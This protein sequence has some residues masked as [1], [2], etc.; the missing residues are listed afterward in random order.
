MSCR[1]SADKTGQVHRQPGQPAYPWTDLTWLLYHH[2]VSWAYYISAGAQPDCNHGIMGCHFRPQNA[3]TPSIWNP[4]PRF[5]D[6][7]QTHQVNHV[8]DTS[9]FF[10]AAR[11]GRLPAVSWVIPNYAQSEHPPASIARGQA[12]VTSVVNAVMRSKDWRSSAIFLTWDDWG[13]FYDHVKPPTVDSLG[14][15]LRVPGLVISPYARQRLHRPPDPE[16]GRLPQV[17]R[18]RLPGRP[19]D[20]P[21]DRRPA[22]LTAQRAREPADPGRRQGRLQLP[23]AAAAADGAEAAAIRPQ[24]LTPS[25]ADPA[26]VYNAQGWQLAAITADGLV[27]FRSANGA[28][29]TQLLPDLATSIPQPTDEGRTYLDA[30]TSGLS[31]S[32]FFLMFTLVTLRIGMTS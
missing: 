2:D 19:A 24:P 32:A 14:Y 31:S 18:G 20:Q 12:W 16:P 10:K 25:S 3:E 15:G 29:G 8:Q 27:Q 28:A 30:I 9:L 4:L 5:T 23:S 6:V 21:Q 13:G 7:R 11:T 26:T 22:G 1:P 17:H